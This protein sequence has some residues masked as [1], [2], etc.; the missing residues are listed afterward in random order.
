MQVLH[1]VASLLQ[2]PACGLLAC[3]VDPVSFGLAPQQ[4]VYAGTPVIHQS[5]C[6]QLAFGVLLLLLLH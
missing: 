5:C 6:P 1:G 4:L 2:L 3:Q